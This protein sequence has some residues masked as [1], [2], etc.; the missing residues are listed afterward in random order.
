MAVAGQCRARI[1][2][3]GRLKT[4]AAILRLQ[5]SS[6]DRQWGRRLVMGFGT[7]SLNV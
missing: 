6:K 7:V 2:S 4:V 1:A 3:V 5:P